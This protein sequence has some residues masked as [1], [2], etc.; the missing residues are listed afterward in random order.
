MRE[1]AGQRRVDGI[2]MEIKRF[3]AQKDPQSGKPVITGSEFYHLT[4]VLRYKEGYK[5]IA[6]MGDGK[7]R[8]CTVEKLE[9]D[10]AVLKEESCTDCAGDPSFPL[11]LFQSQP[12]G[13]KADFIV[14]KAVELGAERIAF[15]ASEHSAAEKFNLER[16]RKIAVEA[17]K[18]CGRSRAA[19]VEFLPDFASVLRASAAPTLIMPY[20]RAESGSMAEALEG[21]TGAVDVIVGSEGGFSESEAQAAQ[22]AGAKLVTLGRRI[23]RCETA[24][25]VTL[26]LVMYERGELGK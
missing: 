2:L 19:E 21:S 8:L 22:A 11:T 26:A 13:A 14:Q 3:F 4:R 24:A 25:A 18:Q 5:A 17:C 10:R 20:E 12:K 16:A 1:K 9:K 6:C 23:L 15:F 7:D